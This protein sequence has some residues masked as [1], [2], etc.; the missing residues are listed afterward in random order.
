MLT[1]SGAWEH[2]NSRFEQAGL[3]PTIY[4]IDN[5]CSQEMRNA[6]AKHNTNLQLDR[7]YLHRANAAERAIQTTKAHMKAVLASLDPQFPVKEWDR[8]LPQIETTLN[9]L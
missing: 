3:T 5:E 8:L 1:L 4:L 2:L 7:P 9:L 6:F